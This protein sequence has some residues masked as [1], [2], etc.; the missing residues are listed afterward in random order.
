VYLVRGYSSAKLTLGVIAMLLVVPGLPAQA[1]APF[2]QNGRAGFVVSHIEYALSGEAGETAACPS[3]MSRNMAE[4]FAMTPE[5][6][7]R[8]A[9]SDEEYGTRV[10][11]GAGV[12]ST[13]PNGQ[14][15][16]LNPEAGQ[17]DPYFRTVEASDIP[18]LGI[19]IDGQV[20]IADGPAQAGLCPH[21]D[22]SGPDGERGIDNQFFRVVGCSRSFQST[23]QSNTY[24]IEMLTGSWGIIITVD[25]VDSIENDDDVEVGFFANADPIQLSP[26]REPL[27]YAT[28]ITDQDPRFRAT[29]H[30]RIKDGVLTT[31]PTDMRFHSVVNSMLLER[32]LRGA[33][34]QATLSEKGVLEG[35]LAGYTPVEEMYDL[36]YGYRNGKDRN[37]KLAPLKLRTGTGNGAAFV[38]GHTCHGAYYALYQH[39]D[40]NPD[41]ATGKCTSISTQYRVKA[42]PAF[43]VDS[44]TA[45]TSEASDETEHRDDKS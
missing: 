32:S 40:S 26:G 29:A 14:N 22:F 39:A 43:V 4:I 2:V 37:G 45:A 36:Q 33:V 27:D 12:L 23:G 6:K 30:G 16:C 17:P 13:A 15:L 38:L 44:E 10:R 8:A 42:I 31:E 28:Y 41:P 7:R 11:Q 25:G 35:Y 24:A 9:E 1:E 21:D 18:V 19:D 3:G 20:S 34:L 5:G